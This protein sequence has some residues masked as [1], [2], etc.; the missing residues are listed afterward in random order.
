MDIKDIFEM[1]PEVHLLN[2]EDLKKKCAE[3]ILD[4]IKLGGWEEK[5]VEKCP[6]T[7]DKLKPD[8]PANLIGHIRRVTGV[9]A[10]VFDEIKDWLNSLAVCDHDIIIAGAL[11]HGVGKFLEYDLDKNGKACYSKTGRM[12][13]YPC[14]GAW[15][16]ME[17]GLPEKVV[18]I[19]VAI[20]A[21]YSPDGSKA[22]MT[23]ESI[24]VKN[25]EHICF[26]ALKVLYGA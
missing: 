16:A 7:V 19:I 2:N 22:A 21:E 9:C 12:F 23:P 6:I 14:S 24:V 18:H 1:I 10:E 20:S 11:L 3:T 5:G 25:A 15:L 13:R 26:G 8:C 4:A 17:H